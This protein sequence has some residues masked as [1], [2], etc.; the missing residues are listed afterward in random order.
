MIFIMFDYSSLKIQY[1][2]RLMLSYCWPRGII[3]ITGPKFVFYYRNRAPTGSFVC[4]VPNENTPGSS[5]HNNNQCQGLATEII[6]KRGVQWYTT[7][8][9]NYY[10]Y[11]LLDTE[12]RFNNRTYKYSRSRKLPIFS[13]LSMISTVRMRTRIQYTCSVLI[14][15]VRYIVLYKIIINTAVSIIHVTIIL[16]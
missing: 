8:Y 10:Y 5:C 2:Q 16:E 9:N 14:I 11:L 6:I 13:S 12:K 7:T 1:Y 3:D 15:P 4:A